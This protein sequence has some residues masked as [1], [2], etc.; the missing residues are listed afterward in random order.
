MK[1]LTLL[2]L[3]IILLLSSHQVFA[4]N[5]KAT[6]KAF[7]NP[8]VEKKNDHSS[9]NEEE[10]EIDDD[11]I[12]SITPTISTAPTASPEWKNHGEYVR[13]VAK[14][15]ENGKEVSEAARSDI[16]KKK[17]KPSVTPSVSPSISPVVSPSI[18]V[19]PTPTDDPNAT[20]SPTLTITPSPSPE[21][22]SA[23]QLSMQD[24]VKKLEEILKSLKDLFNI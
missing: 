12:I 7:N 3:T 16:G 11:N 9:K 20:P 22:Q 2:T 1:K 19:S 6:E 4:V 10:N 14:D 8:S 21:P 17:Y 24:V 18:T 5:D 13:S 23:I 15:H